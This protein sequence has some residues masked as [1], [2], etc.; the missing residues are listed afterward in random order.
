V[1]SEKD[2]NVPGGVTSTKAAEDSGAAAPTAVVRTFV[3]FVSIVCRFKRLSTTT[4]VYMH[5]GLCGGRNRGWW[6]DLPSA[7]HVVSIFNV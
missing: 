2:A 4:Y 7:H 1:L 6:A 5:G 3:F